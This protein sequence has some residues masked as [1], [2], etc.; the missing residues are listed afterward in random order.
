M[1]LISRILVNFLPVLALLYTADAADIAWTTPSGGTGSASVAENNGAGDAVETVVATPST[2]Q[3]IG[4]Y[5]L[6]TTGSPFSLSTGGALTVTTANSLDHEATPTYTI[7]IK[8]VDGAQSSTATLTV[9]VTDAND[10]PTWS[11]TS[12]DACATDGSTA[13]TSVYTVSAS[14]E[15]TGD[16]LSYSITGGNT[17]S[18]FTIAG[19]EIRVANTLDKAT[20]SSYPLQVEVDD[21][22][23]TATTTVSVTVSSSCNSATAVI[24]SLLTILTAL[25]ISLN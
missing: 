1:Q 8:V 21:G 4:D 20:T 17:D 5:T 23:A 11:A 19:S 22:T 10:D 24:V 14:D 9:S 13:G 12:Y 15:D 6:V 16:S 18:D 7:L 25:V 2:G 3:T